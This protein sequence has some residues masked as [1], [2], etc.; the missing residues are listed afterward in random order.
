MKSPTINDK[1]DFQEMS[2]AMKNQLG[3]SNDEYNYILKL[4]ASTLLIGN[5]DFD[6]A[7]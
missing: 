6:D 2:L 1:A 3:F 4:V 5:L 7:E